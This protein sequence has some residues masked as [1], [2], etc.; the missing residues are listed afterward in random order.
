MRWRLLLL[1]V[2]VRIADGNRFVDVTVAYVDVLCS[3]GV[4]LDEI[5]LNQVGGDGIVGDQ[6][7]KDRVVRYQIV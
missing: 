1:A 2:G 6:V 3:F 7:V 5:I 4:Q